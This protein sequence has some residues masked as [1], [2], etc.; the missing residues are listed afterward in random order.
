MGVMASQI[1]SLVIVYSTV[2][3]D[4]DQ[5]KRQSSASLAF[6][7]GIHQWPVNSQHKCPV[8]QKCFLLMTSSWEISP[9]KRPT[10]CRCLNVLR[11]NW[12]SWYPPLSNKSLGCHWRVECFIFTTAM[13]LTFCYIGLR[14]LW[15]ICSIWSIQNE[16]K[17]VDEHFPFVSWYSLRKLFFKRV[18]WAF[19]LDDITC[20]DGLIIFS[21]SPIDAPLLVVE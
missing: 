9:A 5:R 21:A 11:K 12:P 19:S 14:S 18:A 1:T 3:S 6:V 8:T 16:T 7:R 4:A 15:K 17:L 20:I 2:Y 10:C 13:Q